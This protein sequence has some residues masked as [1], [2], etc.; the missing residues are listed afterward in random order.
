M[1]YLIKRSGFQT[2]DREEAISEA[3]RVYLEYHDLD[4]RS[5]G[6]IEN[7]FREM[8]TREEGMVRDCYFEGWIEYG[9]IR[10]TIIRR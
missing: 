3:S 10:V 6:R 5:R 7:T 9:A 2:Y 1:K 4:N 8:L